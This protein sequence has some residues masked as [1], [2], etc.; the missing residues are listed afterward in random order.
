MVLKSEIEKAYLLQQQKLK[1]NKQEI[2]REKNAHLQSNASF[3][4]VI[5]GIR[6]S[7]KSTLL[8]QQMKNYKKIA[9]LNFEDPRLFNFELEDFGKLD[10]IIPTNVEAYFF[11]EIQNVEKW[12]VYVRQLHDDGK[13]VYL[14]GSNASMLSKD[15]GTRLTGR[16]LNSELFPFSYQEFLRFEKKTN[17]VQSLKNYLIDGGFPEYLKNKNIEILQNLFK[18]IL[19]RDIA[20]RY[21]VR[22]TKSLFDIALYLLS[23]IGK[24]SS[25]TKIKNI[26][27]IGS[28]HSVI[29]YLNWMEDAYLLFFVHRFSWSAKS[30]AINPKK[31]YAIDNGLIDANSLSFSEDSG[32]RLENAVFLHL[33]NLGKKVFYFK[34]K[35][36]C[37]FVIFE[38]NSC[39]LALQVCYELNSDNKKREFN[40]LLEAMNF[41]NLNTGIIITLNQKDSISVDGK[42]IELVPAYEFFCD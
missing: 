25:Y 6:R 27:Q 8:R 15:L 32:R 16:S 7:G 22:N 42:I 24:E 18:D 26:F 41:F 35:H 19:L 33:R 36:E 37:D 17:N 11:D 39:V 40:G 1:Q 10:E 5:S 4:E 2:A 31:V 12:E 29:D 28:T 20:V 13:K 34:E 14:T 30:I 21:A 9:Y 3:V 38:K 23:N